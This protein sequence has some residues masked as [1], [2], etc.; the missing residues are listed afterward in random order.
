MKEEK[1]EYTVYE[2]NVLKRKQKDIFNVLPDN[3]VEITHDSGMPLYLHRLT[4]VATFGRPYF[5]GPGSAKHHKVPSSAIPCLYYKKLL[6]DE[7]HKKE[8]E[9]AQTSKE[10]DTS[11]VLQQLNAPA[12][13]VKSTVDMVASDLTA[14]ELHE[15][16][17][18]LFE[19][20]KITYK[21]F[22]DWKKARAHFKELKK[23]SYHRNQL[24]SQKERPSELFKFF[25][26]FKY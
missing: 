15:Y 7:E 12:L 25:I 1:G 17:K 18:N 11:D 3:W 23:L 24:M 2:K 26:H 22:K 16:A 19:F 8:Q 21:K 5:L 6:K 4:R 20:K 14:T 9:T 10:D 13:E